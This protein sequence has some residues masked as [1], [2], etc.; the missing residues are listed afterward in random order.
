MLL[1]LGVSF[2][3]IFMSVN[4]AECPSFEKELLTLINVCSL[5]NLSICN[6][7]YLSDLILYSLRRQNSKCNCV[8]SWSLFTV[9]LSLYIS[10]IVLKSSYDLDHV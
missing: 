9:Y 8:S 10:V 1:I 5:C 6:F 3:A 2:G 4:I 7:N